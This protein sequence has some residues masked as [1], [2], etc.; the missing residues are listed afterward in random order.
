M[1]HPPMGEDSD[2]KTIATTAKFPVTA[3]EDLTTAGRLTIETRPPQS[4]KGAVTGLLS[5]T[6]GKVGLSIFVTSLSDVL[7][8]VVGSSFIM[9]ATSSLCVWLGVG[10]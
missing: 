5:R 9:P 6:L 7:A 4:D 8:F 3:E 2:I 10:I 1:L